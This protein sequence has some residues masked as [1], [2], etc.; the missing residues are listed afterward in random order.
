MKTSRE[1]ITA[2]P[3]DP[4]DDDEF[5]PTASDPENNDINLEDIYI[6]GNYVRDQEE[7]E[8]K[9]NLERKKESVGNKIAEK[10]Y[11]VTDKRGNCV[12]I[13][14]SINTVKIKSVPEGEVKLTKKIPA[15]PRDRLKRLT[16]QRLAK[17]KKPDKI[18]F[19]KQVPSH[20]RLRLKRLMK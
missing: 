12:N 8:V 17:E 4:Q 15:H 3:P 2:I 16:K 19:V 13:N 5:R 20:P 18:V 7:M 11:R 14:C 6:E 10:K 1:T 9:V